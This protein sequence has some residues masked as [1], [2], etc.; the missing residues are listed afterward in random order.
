ML[1]AKISVFVFFKTSAISWTKAKPSPNN[2]V[3]R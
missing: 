3:V 1:A 2:L